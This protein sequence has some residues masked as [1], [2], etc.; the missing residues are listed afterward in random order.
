[1]KV[2]KKKC[3]PNIFF[4][5]MYARFLL[6]SI[7]LFNPTYQSCL[8]A[9][10]EL[11]GKMWVNRFQIVF[12]YKLICALYFTF[13]DK[14]IS[15]DS[16]IL[17]PYPKR[18]NI[19]LGQPAMT[20]DKSF[21]VELDES[22]SDILSAAIER[23]YTRLE[24]QTGLFFT[25]CA[26][27]DKACSK[28]TI[29]ITK[30]L[31]NKTQEYKED[32]KYHL[33]VM[34]NQT[35][36][37]SDSNYGILRGIET[38]LQ[39]V[40]NGPNCSQVPAVEITDEPRFPWRGLMLD[41]A[42]HF[43]PV[44]D[45]KR[46]L[47]GMASAKLNIFHWHLTDDQGWRF[48][49]KLYPK[50]HEVGGN[51]KYYT[52]KQIKDIVHHA[53]LLGIR[54]VPE[55]DLPGHASSIAVAYPGLMSELKEYKHEYGWGVFEPLLDPSN[56]MV[57]KFVDDLMGEAAEMFKD[58]YVHIGGDEVNP[59]QWIQ[60]NIIKEFM[61]SENISD[62]HELHVY[63]N[64]RISKILKKHGKKM[65][66]WDETL[67]KDLPM[68]VIIQSWRGQDTLA[69]AA[70]AG[71][72]TILSSGYYIDQPQPTS[73]HYRNDPIPSSSKL[74]DEIHDHESW[75]TWSFEAPRKRG[76]PVKGNFTIISSQN[77]IK[78]GYID[79]N[80]RSRQVIN[81]IEEIKE[82]TSFWVD[83]WMSKT[84]FR[85]KF[86]K[87]QLRGNMVVGNA[88]YAMSGK[89]I[90]GSNSGSDI[91]AST[92]PD[93][94]L[95][96]QRLKEREKKNIL[97]G[98]IAV[99]S[100]LIKGD[101]FDLRVWPRT[102]AIAERLWSPA[103]ITDEENMY[104]RMKL[105]GDWSTISVGLQ[106]EKNEQQGLKRLANGQ[107]INS[108]L[109]LS[110]AVEQAQYYHRHH[111]KSSNE[112]YDQFD[113]LNRFADVI[114]PESLKVRELNKMVDVF[115]KDQNNTVN[116]EEMKNLFKTW[117]DNESDLKKT[118]D[119]GSCS[120]H[121]LRPIVEHVRLISVLA[122]EIIEAIIKRKSL[123]VDEVNNAKVTLN[124]AQEI[125]DELVVSS[126]YPVEK[127]LYNALWE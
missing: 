17:M 12:L 66:G 64:N 39:L 20:I 121:N 49:S 119:A 28:L 16:L 5:R 111:E 72:K 67:H 101:I 82:R 10:Q 32:E 98:E 68:D 42:R 57:Y 85:V 60:S 80:G 94:Q 43:I 35:T 2:Y 115:L 99:W 90:S 51:G 8:V 22:K 25:K 107:N 88:Q 123:T 83:S 19:L 70:I 37:S 74:D 89:L 63:F 112:N 4:K 108:L 24:T 97:G 7:R 13:A 18:V 41:S 30:P 122:L 6:T 81:N 53:Y 38:F 1:M 69:K 109:I 23:L 91:L 44:Q 117:I 71:H 92:N 58:E 113:P 36:L 106:F 75:E 21:I 104:H 126:A 50:L 95:P 14:M 52:Q 102:Y 86:N 26:I 78:R 65:M 15:D 84:E 116:T 105:I 73:F 79:F 114:P 33:K 124:N 31:V 96:T 11:L 9:K 59:K 62:T 76:A 40:K 48:E 125:E 27:E 56:E 47:D 29:M 118:I 87:N 120:L 61:E 46:L 110:Q 34:Q 45:I 100:E 3:I 103:S 54:V 127:L 77:N 55:I 93:N